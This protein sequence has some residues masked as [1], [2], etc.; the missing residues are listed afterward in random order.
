MF[1]CQTKHF[2]SNKIVLK[3]LNKHAYL[4]KDVKQPNTLLNG[5]IDDTVQT[6]TVDT[7]ACFPT[8]GTLLIGTEQ[9][10]Y[11]CTTATTFIGVTREVNSTTKASALDDASVKLVN[12]TD[13][14]MSGFTD[15]LR[16]T[17]ITA[18]P[19]TAGR[20]AGTAGTNVIYERTAAGAT[21]QNLLTVDGGTKGIRVGEIVVGAGIPAGTSV[22]AITSDTQVQIRNNQTGA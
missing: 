1:S 3:E 17:T 15:I 4:N 13:G 18:V 10:T 5:A 21:G 2:G 9:M 7:T 19:A 20:T 6:L 22:A 16:S 8:S 12:F 14:I 11:T